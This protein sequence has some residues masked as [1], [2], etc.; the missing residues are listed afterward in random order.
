MIIIPIS[1]LF[2]AGEK[3]ERCWRTE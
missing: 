2:P 1:H 3:A